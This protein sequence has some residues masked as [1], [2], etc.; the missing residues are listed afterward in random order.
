MEL[1]F[2]FIFVVFMAFVYVSYTRFMRFCN[3]YADLVDSIT[4]LQA[5]IHETQNELWY[6]LNEYRQLQSYAQQNHS[7]APYKKRTHRAGRKHRK[8]SSYYNNNHQEGPESK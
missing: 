3:T 5:D 2:A 4:K 6:M 1:A 8:S 7:P